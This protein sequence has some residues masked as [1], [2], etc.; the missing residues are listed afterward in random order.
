M[1]SAGCAA[2]SAT[3]SVWEPRTRDCTTTSTGSRT[4]SPEALSAP[5]PASSCSRAMS[6]G[7]CTQTGRWYRSPAVPCSPTTAC[8]EH[9]GGV[10]STRPLGHLAIEVLGGGGVR[11][12]P[13]R[14]PQEVVHLV[15]KDQLRIFDAL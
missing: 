5:R 4:S 6:S 10:P 14:V 3:D 15:G 13:R 1:T 9:A 8:S 2:S 11:A 7:S 12:Q